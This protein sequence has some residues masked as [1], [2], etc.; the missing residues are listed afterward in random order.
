MKILYTAEAHVDKGRNGH[1]RSSD[2]R[3]DVD[4]SVPEG[5]GGGG[6][7]GTNPEQ[8]F[9]VGYGACFLGAVVVA[10]QRKRVEI[11]ED[12]LSAD[13]KVG[14]GPQAGGAYN[15]AIELNVA[16]PGVEPALAQEI[17]E[18]AHETCPY[19]NATRGNVEVKL[20]VAAPA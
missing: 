11:D 14:L 7:A 15:L 2:G 4:L 13:V 10:A 9:A 6:G 19:S 12:A 16:I 18:A 20:G 3:L 1:G 5:V 8:L 17:V